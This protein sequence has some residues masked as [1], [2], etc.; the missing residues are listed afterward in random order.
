MILW[1]FLH[2]NVNFI[3]GQKSIVQYRYW[4]APSCFD[5]YC[6]PTIAIFHTFQQFHY[7]NRPPPLLN[8]Q[9]PNK[10]MNFAATQM[11]SIGSKSI[12]TA[13]SF[14]IN[15]KS[16]RVSRTPEA[17]WGCQDELGSVHIIKVVFIVF[18]S[19]MDP[20]SARAVVYTWSDK[21]GGTSLVCSRWADDR[22]R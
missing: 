21:K 4:Y 7:Q 17:S 5:V 6:L 16:R 13:I 22:S 1:I 9:R 12:R 20:S 10:I 3:V 18:L 14:L 11:L 8:F 19:L 15:R 2:F